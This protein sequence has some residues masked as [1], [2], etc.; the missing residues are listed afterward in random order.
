MRNTQRQTVDDDCLW[1]DCG[2]PP[3]RF[4]CLPMWGKAI[5]IY[6]QNPLCEEITHRSCL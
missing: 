6:H 2:L 1:R 4:I 5:D 3:I